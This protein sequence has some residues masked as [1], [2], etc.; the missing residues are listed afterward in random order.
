M[1]IGDYARFA[2]VH[3]RGLRGS[4]ELLSAA[5]LQR[6]HTPNGGYAM[7][8]GVQTLTGTTTWVHVGSAGTFAVCAMIQPERDVA[9]VIATN[10]GSGGAVTAVQAAALEILTR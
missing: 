9:V 3:L 7:G 6:L 1:A 2:R 10:A 8:W 4:P 5:T